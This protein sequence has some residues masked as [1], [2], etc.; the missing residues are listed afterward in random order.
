MA[1]VA[2]VLAVVLIALGVVVLL[3]DVTLSV[4]DA[5]KLS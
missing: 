4:A 1:V 3:D 5:A 2:R